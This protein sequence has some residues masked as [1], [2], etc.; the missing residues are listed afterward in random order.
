MRYI[1]NFVLIFND[2]FKQKM[3]KTILLQFMLLLSITINAQKDSVPQLKEIYFTNKLG[4]KITGTVS[5]SEKMVYM[6]IVSANAIGEKVVIKMDEGEDYFY[7]KEF[8]GAGS[9]FKIAIKENIQKVK[10]VIYNA[11][12]KKHVKRRM[13]IE[14]SAK[15]EDAKS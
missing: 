10:L 5:V 6:V 3:N 1:L 8:L 4:E 2:K 14:G 12:K 9:S 11:H 13:K 7:K 15:A